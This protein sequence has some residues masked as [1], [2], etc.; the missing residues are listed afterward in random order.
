M[1]VGVMTTI[2]VEFVAEP[3]GLAL[4]AD[5][6]SGKQ[7]LIVASSTSRLCCVD[8]QTGTNS[9]NVLATDF[10]ADCVLIGYD[11]MCGGQVL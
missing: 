11:M 8:L 7:Q 9:E 3:H 1:C 4:C 2:S 10:M 6:Q 5:A